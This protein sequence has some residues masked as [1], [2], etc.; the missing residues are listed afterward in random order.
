MKG[1]ILNQPHVIKVKQALIPEP[2]AREVRIKL[3]MIGICGSD[4]HLF[5]GHRLLEKPTIIGH[6]GLGYIDKLG[7]GVLNRHLGERVV[8]EPNIPCCHCKY[9]RSGRG[10]ICLNKRVIGVNEVGCFAEYICLPEA[11][12]WHIPDSISDADAVTIEPMVVGYSALFSSKA[13]S[14][15]T[16]AVI[17]LGAIGLLVTHLA[18]A[19]GYKVLVTELN[20]KKLKMAT[21]LGAIATNDLQNAKNTLN[22]DKK[23]VYTEGSPT[24]EQ[25]EIL[26]KIWEENDVVAVFECAGSAYTASLVTAAA[27]RGSEII[28]VGLSGNLATFKSLKIAR[29]GIT[30]IP[31]IIYDHPFDF[32]RTIQLIESKIIRPSFIISR[33]MDLNDIQAAL[34]IAAKGDDS[35]IVI[36][37]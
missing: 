27:P 1:A 30:I 23:G 5:L 32:K 26:A 15:D 6:E 33:Y 12:C 4:V 11:F 24:A 14:G 34:E 16:I 20:E 35:K 19:L 17:G 28:L 22:N 25:N 10:N 8:I 21:D 13:Q 9:C 3:K 29:E 18:L 37:V 2:R 7:A 36:T 31:S